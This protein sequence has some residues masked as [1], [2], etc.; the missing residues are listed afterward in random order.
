MRLNSACLAGLAI[1]AAP[2]ALAHTGAHPVAGLV[3]GFIHPFTGLDHMAAMVAVGLWAALIAPQRVWRLPLAFMAVMALG[4]ALGVVG[5]VLPDLEIG[6]AAS[7]LLLGGLLLAMIRLPLTHAAVWVGLFA[8]LHGFAHGREMT[9]DAD[10]AAYAAGFVVATG[11]LHACG[12]GLGRLLLRAP[13]LYRGVGGLIGA[14]GA[15]LLMAPG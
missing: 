11:M 10:F 4:A 3:T 14:W 2:A 12:I 5:V 8:L 9:T 15:Y 13:I 6:V 1:L 7:V